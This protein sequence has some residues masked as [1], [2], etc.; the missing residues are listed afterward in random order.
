LIDVAYRS[1]DDGSLDAM[2]VRFKNRAWY[3]A[4][5][6]P[7]NYYWLFSKQVATFRPAQYWRRIKVP[8]LLVYGAHDERVPPRE[9]VS[10]IQAALKAGGNGN[11]TVKMYSHADHTFTIVDPPHKGGWP[12]HEPDYADVLV[13]WILAPR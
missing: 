8:V 7:D 10:A 6:P 13:N 12:K 9:S 11:V 3:F 4:P 1:K 5:P 2:S